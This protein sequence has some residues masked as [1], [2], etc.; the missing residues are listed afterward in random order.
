MADAP[1]DKKALAM[2]RLMASR[3]A[4]HG[5]T[6]AGPLHGDTTSG[7]DSQPGWLSSLSGLPGVSSA[8]MLAKAIWADSPLSL[9]AQLAGLQWRTSVV[10]VVRKHPLATLA[11]AAAAGYALIRHR[12]AVLGLITGTLW[13]KLAPQANAVAQALMGAATSAALDQWLQTSDKPSPEG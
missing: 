6:E 2:V 1:N 13:P 8:L 4:L 12:E 5:M 11:V 9:P 10:P 7:R 3:A